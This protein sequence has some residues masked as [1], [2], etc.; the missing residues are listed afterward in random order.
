MN[1]DIA[2]EDPPLVLKIAALLTAPS[3]RRRVYI[4]LFHKYIHVCDERCI[5]AVGDAELDWRV[6]P[7]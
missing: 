4:C 1:T 2:V 6:C 5:S 3:P 7:L